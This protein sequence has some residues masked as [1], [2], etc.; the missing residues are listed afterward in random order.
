MT[1]VLI[2]AVVYIGVAVVLLVFLGPL[3]RES[4]QIYLEDVFPDEKQAATVNNMLLIAFAL[5]TLAM[6]SLLV[7]LGIPSGGEAAVRVLVSRV[8]LLLLIVGVSHLVN[9]AI[10]GTL[11]RRFHA[12]APV[13]LRYRRCAAQ[14]RR[15]VLPQLRRAAP[16]SAASPGRPGQR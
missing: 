7:G 1:S 15:A 2:S 13:G 5:F 4:G 8:A 9:L 10:F 6:A 11:R 3:M 16:S 14:L 12:E